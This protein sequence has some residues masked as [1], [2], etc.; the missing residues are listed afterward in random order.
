MPVFWLCYRHNNQISVIIEPAPSLI[1]ARMA[2]QQNKSSDSNQRAIRTSR[3]NEG[4]E[5][6]GQSNILNSVRHYAK[7]DYDS[8]K[9]EIDQL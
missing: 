5:L 4:R 9:K 1:H 8:G 2:G 7:H 6:E 3:P